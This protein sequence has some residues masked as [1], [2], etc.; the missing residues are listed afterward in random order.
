VT[1]PLSYT[2][3]EKLKVGRPVDRIS[4][5]AAQCA[6]K[7]VL[8]LGCYDETALIKQDTEHWLHGRVAKVAASVIGIDSSAGIPGEG[9]PT[10]PT[11]RILRGDAAQSR[12]ICD[13]AGYEPDIIVAGELVEHLAD[14]QTFLRRVREA[15]P[16]RQ[17]VASTPNATSLT[18][19]ILALAGRESSHQDHLQIYSYKTLS[20][21]CS[22]SE[23]GD[24]TII[25]Y[26]VRYSEF[27]LRNSGVARTLIMTAQKSMNCLEWMWP[28]LSG[29]LIVHV[30]KM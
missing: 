2:P 25:P 23:F 3:F 5:I 19:V 18:N 30:R 13:A 8:D 11:S 1:P 29:G 24:W 6:G 27:V 16:G 26:Y 22:R 28:L 9:I 10:G 4:Y 7:R 21:L 17:L 20:T 12:S 15:F 14:T